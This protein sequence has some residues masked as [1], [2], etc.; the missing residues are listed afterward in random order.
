MMSADT[1][2]RLWE[3]ITVPVEQDP[4]KAMKEHFARVNLLVT[5]AIS[6]PFLFITLAGWSSGRIP[7]DTFF[8][9]LV[10]TVM[11]GIGIFLCSRGRWRIA[12]FIPVLLFY[13]AAA[14]GNY[15]GGISVPAILL[16]AICIIMSAM[17]YGGALQ[18]AALIVCSGT[19]LLIAY[20]H[21]NGYIV[22]MR[23]DDTA[24]YNRVTIVVASILYI[25]FL[26]RFI[27]GR[28]GSSLVSVYN[29]RREIELLA[30]KNENLY[31]QAR[32]DLSGRQR[33]EEEL[34]EKN[35][36]LTV[37]NEEL[38]AA[39]ENLEK[40]NEELL[41][42]SGALK[43]S[44]ER[45]RVSAV[46]TGEIIYDL[47]VTTGRIYWAGAIEQVT[48]YS[49]DEFERTNLKEWGE[50]IHPQDRTRA[51]E[52]LDHAMK[53]IGDYHLEYRFRRKDGS[54]IDMEDHGVFMSDEK[55]RAGRMLGIM[56]DI[57]ERVRT[58]KQIE[59]SLHEKEVLLKEVH[60]RVK[61]NFQ[62][63]LSL[64]NLQRG[65]SNDAEIVNTIIDAQNRIR[66]MSLVHEK[67]YQSQNFASIN[68]GEYLRSMTAELFRG[69]CADPGRIALEIQ[70]VSAELPIGSAI[71]LGLA[72]N[73]LITN[74]LKYAFPGERKGTV[75]IYFD[76][77]PGGDVVITVE[78]N[79]VG[80]P[81]GF[82]PSKSDTLGFKLVFL[83]IR[84]QLRGDVV[85]NNEHGTSV[86]LMLSGN[87]EPAV[88]SIDD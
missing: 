38:V 12:G 39:F 33:A 9:F 7:P 18:W 10:M 87:Q 85:I 40:S 75:K 2:K 32:E 24:F 19:Y 8:W 88:T 30:L 71:P 14:A 53:S 52:M 66:A 44:E 34:Q 63:I 56:N 5:M 48:G 28:Y 77:T 86:T 1:L 68:F 41:E 51:L 43:A 31:R 21:Y 29:D 59:E 81:K 27:V 22:R 73:E 57:T 47:N 58:R 79:G 65:K 13:A 84:D 26:V 50:M 74:A 35:E 55:G 49:S 42:L 45:F 61:N 82:E 62:V 76:K 17:I 23:T 69:Q 4:L 83:L 46:Q 78:D 54:Y 16:Y 36:E 6:I 3:S 67:L 11:Y 60:H 80:I 70:A 20:A 37:V 15:I 72:V 25:S 64:L